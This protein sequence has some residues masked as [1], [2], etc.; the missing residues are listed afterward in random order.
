[1]L[2]YHGVEHSEDGS[3]AEDFDLILKAAIDYLYYGSGHLQQI[4]F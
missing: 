1:M 3:V 4:G 2:R